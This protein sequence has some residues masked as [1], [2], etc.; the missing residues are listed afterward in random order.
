M[1]DGS[2][3][4]CFAIC[5]GSGNRRSRLGDIIGFP[6][7]WFRSYAT[8][9]FMTPY[10]QI[11]TI[12]K[13]ALGDKLL[14]SMFNP[15]RKERVEKPPRNKKRQVNLFWCRSRMLNHCSLSL[16]MNML[17]RLLLSSK[18]IRL[19]LTF[20]IPYI[21]KRVLPFR[22]RT[23][24]TAMPVVGASASERGRSILPM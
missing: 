2:L 6:C 22:R 11:D 12:V 23:G 1:E 9:M 4:N 20:P 5:E 21:P 19:S 16:G 18:C 24:R 13:Q 15:G 7:Y 8:V 17:T 14:W 3:F 10:N